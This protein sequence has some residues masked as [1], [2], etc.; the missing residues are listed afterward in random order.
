MTI[1]SNRPIFTTSYEIILVNILPVVVSA[2]TT[3]PSEAASVKLSVV[4]AGE[5]KKFTFWWIRRSFAK[6]PCLATWS[7]FDAIRPF[8]ISTF[9][10]VWS[11]I[12]NCRPFFDTSSGRRNVHVYKL[13]FV[14]VLMLLTS[15]PILPVGSGLA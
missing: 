6:N 9:H 10:S 3:V 13:L 14:V 8:A 5:R 15:I 1:K 11:F 4:T 2:V 7:L 12:L